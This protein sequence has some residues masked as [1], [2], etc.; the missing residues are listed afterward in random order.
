MKVENVLTCVLE[1]DGKDSIPV[2]KLCDFGLSQ[3]LGKDGRLELTK[4]IGTI[5]YMAPELGTAEWVD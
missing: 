3:Y 5:G 1:K 2:L 4:K